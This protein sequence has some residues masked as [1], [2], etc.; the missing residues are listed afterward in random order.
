MRKLTSSL[1]AVLFASLSFTSAYAQ[2][3][4]TPPKLQVAPPPRESNFPISDFSD[5]VSPGS[6]TQ[7]EGGSWRW[8]FAN[9]ILEGTLPPIP[10]Y[11]VDMVRS[12]NGDSNQCY[13]PIFFKGSR[14]GDQNLLFAVRMDRNA[15]MKLCGAEGK[16]W[17]DRAMAEG[18]PIKA[19]MSIA[20]LG[21]PQKSG[22]AT[23]FLFVIDQ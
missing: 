17:I 23:I 18:T 9:Y 8:H 12:P 21:N 22:Y 15:K 13:T 7:T 16:A 2:P 4:N 11:E 1:L 10:G 14:G 19:R 3:K 5:L 6:F 20:V